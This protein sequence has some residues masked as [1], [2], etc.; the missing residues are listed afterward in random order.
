MNVPT[1]DVQK[2]S[3][4]SF[5]CILI[6]GIPCIPELPLSIVKPGIDFDI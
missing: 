2:L 3:S 6:K 5:L 4:F 1:L